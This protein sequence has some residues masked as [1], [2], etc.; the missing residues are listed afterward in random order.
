MERL[1][2]PESSTATEACR[3]RLDISGVV[4]GV[5]FRPHVYR[6]A[7]QN[8]LAGWVQNLSGKVVIEAQG[9]QANI[10]AFSNQLISDSPAPIRIRSI[11]RT[12]LPIKNE[13]GFVIMPSLNQ[14]LEAITFPADLAVCSNCI[15]EITRQTRFH[16]YPFISCTC[17]GP[18]FTTIRSIPYDRQFTS[19]EVFHICEYCKAEF[20]DESNRRFHAQTIA[21]PHCGPS[22]EIVDR[23][24]Q[25][26]SEGNDL[27][28]CQ[29]TLKEGGITAIKGIGGFH[30]I[31]DATQPSSVR[32]LRLRK[33]RPNKP[34]A[35]MA[36]NVAA[37]SEHFEVSAKEQEA[38]ESP[39]A[40]IVLLRP[41]GHTAQTLPLSEIAP[42]MARI[43]V[44]LPY[45]PLHY[46]LFATELMWL[47]A[48]S[49]NASGRPVIY[50]NDEA[51]NHLQGIAD[52]FV[53]HNREIVIWND[54]SVGQVVG[55]EFQ[56]IRRSRGFVPNAI[57]I[58]L[59]VTEEKSEPQW[60]VVV[61]LG[62]ETKNTFCYIFQDKAI[63]SQHMGDIDTL[64]GLAAHQVARNHYETL[65]SRK[66]QIIVYDPH[67]NY[68]LSQAMNK[69]SNEPKVPVYHHHA[70]MASCMA[71]H[72]IASPVIGCILDGTGYGSDEKL[73][74]FEILT[75]DYVD[76][77]RVVH[78]KPIR[79]PGGEAAIRNPW[80]TGL[81]L[82]Y[83]AAEGNVEIFSQ[84]AFHDFP[85]HK[86][87][88]PILLAQ[89][90]GMIPAPEASSAGRLFDGIAAI[91]KVCT[92]C[93]Y[94][95]EAAIR[96]SEIIEAGQLDDG[97]RLDEKYPYVLTNDQW[98]IA[99]MMRQLHQDLQSGLSLIKMVYKFHHTIAYMVLDGA[100]EARLRTGINHVVLSGG[101]WNNRYLQ[102]IAK[103]LLARD[104][105]QVYSHSKVPAGDGG[106]ALGQAV[107]GLWRWAKGRVLIGTVEGG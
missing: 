97:I 77:Q 94:D 28:L 70:H 60:P 48:T 9:P 17:C 85:E 92:H 68:L 81:S 105:F 4:Q 61:G 20:Q 25:K 106:V 41:Q 40:P 22:I 1:A 21:C 26:L 34:L 46:L 37:V 72:H 2:H 71:E 73:W 95:G 82:L 23:F 87:Q 84:Y 52:L 19:F 69:G 51:V 88:L 11:H 103:Q 15:D 32:N 12:R 64:E 8:R 33:G 100:R 13:T 59:P 27:S 75:G 76:F 10:E 86:A 91:L 101:V 102:S 14:G 42:G 98:E 7:Q 80:M 58:P 50:T 16:K 89:L 53:F 45:S 3:I 44:F 63:V 74:G 18:R 55:E 38:L 104:G 43:G 29:L 24:G 66:P 93:S 83:E 78:L 65:F 62:A 36:K 31:C 57:E 56:F 49:G 90:S 54:D 30:L 96:L 79:L 39:A 35:I 99:P 47:V 5:G 107:C 6:L 67:P